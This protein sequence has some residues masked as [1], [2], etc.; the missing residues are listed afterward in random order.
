MKRYF[1]ERTNGLIRTMEYDKTGE[2]VFKC[3]KCYHLVT[4]QEMTQIIGEKLD[5]ELTVQASERMTKMFDSDGNLKEIKQSK[6]YCLLC[7]S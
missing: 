6:L 2:K 1:E 7:D 5:K 3:L 4:P